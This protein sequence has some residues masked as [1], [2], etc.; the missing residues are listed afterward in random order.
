M[1]LQY[2]FVLHFPVLGLSN[3]DVLAHSNRIPH[4]PLKY[5][6]ID[7]FYGFWTAGCGDYTDPCTRPCLFRPFP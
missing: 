2:P 4:S 7:T 5:I 1:R 6:L 3:N